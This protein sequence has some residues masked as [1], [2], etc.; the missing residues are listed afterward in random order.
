M[1]QY[2]FSNFIHNQ[3]APPGA[4]KIGIYNSSNQKVGEIPLGTLENTFGTPLYKVGLLSD[5]HVDTTDYNYSKYINSYPYS[6]EGAGDL[7]RALKWFRDVE[8]VDMVCASGDLSQYGEDSEFQ[9][10]QTAVA[11][12]IPNIPFYTCTG[13]HD[14]YSSHSGASTFLNYTRRTLDSTAHSIVTS[15]AYQNSFYFLHPYT[16]ANNETINDVFIFFSMYNYSASNAYLAADLTWLGTI[17]EQYKTNRV[18][19]FTH[20]FFPEYAG[21]LGRV[22][23]SGGIYPPGNWLS[24]SGLT[25]LMNYFSTY[26]NTFWFSGH[27]HWKWD[28][29]RYQ[30]NLNVARY[31]ASG[32]WSI[33]LPSLSLPIDSDYTNTSSETSTNRVE[34]PLETQGAVMDVYEDKIVIRGIDFNIN[35]SQNG[36]T[37]QGYEGSDYVRYLPIAM[38]ELHTGVNPEDGEDIE[39]GTWEAGGWSSSNGTEEDSTEGV[40]RSPYIAV[41]NNHRYYLNTTGSIGDQSDPDSLREVSMGA[42]SGTLDNL[43]YLGR[44]TNHTGFNT[45]SSKI[46]SSSTSLNYLDRS[47]DNEDFTDYLFTQW[48]T[49]TYIR[50]KSYLMGDGSVD[51]PA[52]SIDHGER[53][54]VVAVEAD[55]SVDP[56]DEYVSEYVTSSNLEANSSKPGGTLIQTSTLVNDLGDTYKDYMCVTFSGTQQGFWVTSPTYD[57]S[58]GTNQTA[59]VELVDLKIYS[60][61][62][63]STIL[64][65]TAIS[66]PSY[67]GFYNGTN[68]SGAERYQIVNG[69]QP[70]T[71]ESSSNGRVQFQTSSS[72]SGGTVTVL[73]KVKLN[74]TS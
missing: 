9:M 10:T 39:I 45:V 33:H 49:A 69:F 25:T 66:L 6:D 28:L 44:V 43:S 71:W 7:R 51:S 35:T 59:T 65:Q 1:A 16:N 47:Y 12:Q 27:S 50:F 38:Y 74:Y 32:A 68:Y 55:P 57:S 5:I 64:N 18:F 46:G 40:I 20:L 48:P 2:T 41:D 34:K 17:L 3:I 54:T 26:N 31:G 14:C 23:G 62:Y 58:L 4:K 67:L 29:Q 36:D 24:G 52:I 42:W 13:N 37:T 61:A 70:S 73:M 60:G 72:Y 53:I 8:Q 21:N 63:S 19:I 15:T 30:K 22:N 56:G 11:E